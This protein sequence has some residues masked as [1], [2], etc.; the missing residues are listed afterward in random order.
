VKQAAKCGV[1]CS[2]SHDTADLNHI[3][4]YLLKMLTFVQLNVR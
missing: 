3:S 2:F 1:S 4:N